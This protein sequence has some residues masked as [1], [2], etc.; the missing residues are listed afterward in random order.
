MAKFARI[1]VLG[2]ICSHAACLARTDEKTETLG[3]KMLGYMREYREIILAR[4]AA[5]AH[6]YKKGAY[7]HMSDIADDMHSICSTYAE[8]LDHDMHACDD[9]IISTDDIDVLL[10]TLEPPI[11]HEVDRTFKL[12][13]TPH[14]LKDA[15]LAGAETG[16]FFALLTYALTINHRRTMGEAFASFTVPATVGSIIAY[17]FQL[18]LYKKPFD[19][20]I[21]IIN[22][23]DAVE[24]NMQQHLRKS[25]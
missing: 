16:V 2:I 21:A 7:R 3:K 4:T 14:F 12:I 24:K 22:R 8:A 20:F 5:F 25:K 9:Q 6:A 18:F 1:L 17:G 15:L 19:E 10:K 23:I 13:R 11:T